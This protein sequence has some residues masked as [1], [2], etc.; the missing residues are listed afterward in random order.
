[1]GRTTEATFD[2]DELAKAYAE[3]HRKTDPGVEEIYYLP[4]NAP[5]R[6]IRFLEVNR[7]ISEMTPLEPIDFGVNTGEPDA[8][9]L[10]VLD[11]TPAQWRAIR[12]GELPLPGNW[13]LNG[14]KKLGGV[15]K[16]SNRA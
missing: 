4:T 7:L 16:R 13:A 11:V 9:T 6:E 1:M 5:Q 10:C 15:N 8:H 2:R 12:D 14:K 3:R